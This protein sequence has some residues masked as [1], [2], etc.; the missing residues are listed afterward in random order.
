M[1]FSGVRLALGASSFS[2]VAS[3]A[4]VAAVDL[5]LEVT[6]DDDARYVEQAL[7]SSHNLVTSVDKDG[8]EVRGNCY[9]HFLSLTD[10][11]KDCKMDPAKV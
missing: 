8:K 11:H 5:D 2:L 4:F 6:R 7:E 10:S 3:V 1:V 9:P